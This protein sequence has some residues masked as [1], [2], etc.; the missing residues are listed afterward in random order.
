MANCLDPLGMFADWRGERW[1]AL[2]LLDEGLG[3]VRAL[4]APEETADLLQR[5]AAV[6]LRMGGYGQAR[7]H[8]LAAAEPRRAYRLLGSPLLGGFFRRLTE[9]AAAGITLKDYSQDLFRTA[10]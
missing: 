3:Y 10:P 2:R 1:R 5:R 9:R 6:L 4:Q 8:F 7:E